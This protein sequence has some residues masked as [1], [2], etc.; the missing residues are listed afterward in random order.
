MGRRL[1]SAWVENLASKARMQKLVCSR[2]SFIDFFFTSFTH[3]HHEKAQDDSTD[4]LNLCASPDL[5]TPPPPRVVSALELFRRNC[6][7]LSKENGSV[8]LVALSLNIEQLSSD[9]VSQLDS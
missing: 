9:D 8:D 2:K 4:L 3:V 7:A 6:C 5:R 1:S